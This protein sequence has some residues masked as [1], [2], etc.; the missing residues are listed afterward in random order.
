MLT[1]N[2]F[3]ILKIKKLL[4]NPLKIHYNLRNKIICI[5]KK[6]FK[7]IKWIKTTSKNLNKRL[8]ISI[9]QTKAQNIKITK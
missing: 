9:L 4:I 8:K 3:K 5:T 1:L 7:Q 2:S 6:F